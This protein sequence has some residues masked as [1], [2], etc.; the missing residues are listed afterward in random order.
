MISYDEFEEIVVNVLE[1]DISS[2]EDQKR[3]ISSP[4]NQSLFLVAGPG[5]EDF[6]LGR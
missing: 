1:R 4:A 6:R 3:A 5:S 2:N